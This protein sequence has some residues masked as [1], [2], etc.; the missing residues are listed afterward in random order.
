MEDASLFHLNKLRRSAEAFL[1]HL[2]SRLITE[3]RTPTVHIS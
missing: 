3:K 2:F 1:I